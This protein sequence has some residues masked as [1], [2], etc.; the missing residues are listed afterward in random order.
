VA[1]LLTEATLDLEQTDG[2]LIRAFVERKCPAAFGELVL[3]HGSMVLG[4]CLRVLRHRQDAEDAFQAT[5]LVL[6]RKA[7][8]VSPRNAVGNWLHGV[9]L[10]TAVRARAITMKRRQRETTVPSVPEP[11][12]REAGW[13]D[14][15]E[16]VD[17]ELG[18]LPNHYR[19]VLLLCDLE[20][21]TRTDAARHLGCPEGSVSS[22]LSRARAMLA[23][24]LTKRGVTLPAGAVALLVGRNATAAGVPAALV[25]ATVEAVGSLAAGSALGG[26]GSP[27]V[28]TLS[29]GVLKAMLIKRIITTTTA[30]LALSVTAITGGRLAIGQSE[31][32]GNPMAGKEVTR[33]VAE[34][35]LEPA[36]K[37]GEEAFTAW[38]KEVGGLQAGIGFPPSQKRVYSHGETV[39]L[40]LRARNIG[41][42]AVE[43]KHIWAFFV[44]NPP[45]ITDAD[46]KP[47]QLPK[48]LAE[49]LHMPR[50]T[51]VAPGKEI[52]L[53]EWKLDLMPVTPRFGRNKRFSTLYGTGMFS[54]QCEQILGPTSAN[55]NHPNPTFKDLATGKLELQ[56]KEPEKLPPEKEAITA[57]GKEVGGLQAGLGFRAG[58]K[59]TYFHGET[60]TLIVRLRNVGKEE[61]TF[62]EVIV[63]MLTNPLSVTDRDG[64]AV[65][66]AC[67]QPVMSNGLRRENDK[68]LP[69]KDVEYDNLELQLKPANARD[70][71]QSH[72]TLFGT[73]RFQIRYQ[74]DGLS[75]TGRITNSTGNLDLEVKEAPK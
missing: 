61:V 70:D 47:V 7:G 8:S 43:F 28:T 2:E 27:E 34:K 74:A 53:Y 24:R 22:R 75:A 31:G 67:L 62:R 10:Q 30:V 45:T 9:A 64:K 25:T 17:A 54:V 20:G 3:R 59:R 63:W 35:A 14:V 49:G 41:K 55:P 39:K 33:P 40:V 37:Q 12:A 65:Y 23:K 44:E 13:D 18:R 68:L 71:P 73:G 32:T 57:W 6:A 58:E 16:V 15:A 52:E 51:N 66:V 1:R 42:E 36:A 21:R 4:V 72:M 11:A 50:N 5:F 29:E 56:V 46:G 60:V 69:G 38:G 48:Y 26:G 19:A